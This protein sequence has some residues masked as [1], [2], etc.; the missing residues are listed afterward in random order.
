MC[1]M[2]LVKDTVGFVMLVYAMG[3]G[4]GAPVGGWIYDVMQDFDGVF[5]FC[6]SI[7]NVGA[8]LAIFALIFNRKCEKL[9][10]QYLPL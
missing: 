4:I 2:E 7:Y 5:Y 8:I 9:R 10:S 6:A 3:A 1:G